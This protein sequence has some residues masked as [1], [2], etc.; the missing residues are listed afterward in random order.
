MKQPAP[1]CRLCGGRDATTET[2][3]DGRTVPACGTC[4][5]GVDVAPEHEVVHLEDLRVSTRAVAIARRRPGLTAGEI[6]ELLDVRPASRAADPETRR[7]Y[8]AIIQQLSRA[9]KA[10]ALRAEVLDPDEPRRYYPTAKPWVPPGRS[11][12][13]ALDPEPPPLPARPSADAFF[14]RGRWRSP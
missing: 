4:L 5:A 3:L 14:W 7:L 12:D 10:G 8:D 1:T 6:C 2:D 13:V 9:V 11:A